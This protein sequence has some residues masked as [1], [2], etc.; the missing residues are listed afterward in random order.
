LYWEQIRMEMALENHFKALGK[1][2]YTVKILMLHLLGCLRWYSYSK[3][4]KQYL[5]IPHLRHCQWLQKYIVLC[6]ILCW[7]LLQSL[8][9]TS[10]CLGLKLR[11]MKASYLII[12][13]N[14]SS[15][16]YHNPILSSLKCCF[17]LLSCLV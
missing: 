14:L 1:A 3:Q 10:K 9:N 12:L 4:F 16:H 5:I 15:Y 2:K 7:E 11:L 13:Q 6:L 17:I 8:S